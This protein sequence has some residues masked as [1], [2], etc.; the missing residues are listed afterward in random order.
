MSWKSFLPFEIIDDEKKPSK[1]DVKQPIKEQIA[2]TGAVPNF[3][4][5]AP[6]P[7]YNQTAQPAYNPQPA[8]TPSYSPA[9]TNLSPEDQ[10]KWINFMTGI[11]NDARKANNVFDDFENQVE[12][13]AAIIPQEPARIT[14]VGKLMKDKGHPKSEVIAAANNVAQ[15]INDA[16]ASFLQD[17]GA[18]QKQ[19]VTDL[20]LSIQQKQA[21]IQKLNEEITGL[22][23]SIAENSAKLVI[24]EQGFNQ[25]WGAVIAKL[26]NDS[27]NIN[28]FVQE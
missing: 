25:C 18:R 17:L 24:R 3:N 22:N 7:A 9:P 19:G 1:L 13:L 16:K 11:Y 20:Q 14:A 2:G 21:Q 26:T 6:Q 10:Q 27:N 8:Y 4:M 5:P 23:N 28:A 12:S 15:V